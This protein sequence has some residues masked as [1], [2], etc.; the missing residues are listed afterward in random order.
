MNTFVISKTALINKILS[1]TKRIIIFFNVIL[2]RSLFR[3]LFFLIPKKELII[4]LIHINY[5]RNYKNN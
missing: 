5:E 4:L 2:F 3:S 1:N